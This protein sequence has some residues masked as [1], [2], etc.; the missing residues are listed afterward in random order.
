MALRNQGARRN[1]AIKNSF[2]KEIL[3]KLKLFHSY[4]KSEDESKHCM[5]LSFEEIMFC[6]VAREFAFSNCDLN[7]KV[8]SDHQESGLHKSEIHCENPALKE[9]CERLPKPPIPRPRSVFTTKLDDRNHDP[10]H[11]SLINAEIQPTEV[12]SDDGVS[13]IDCEEMIKTEPIQYSSENP[14]SCTGSIKNLVESVDVD[15]QPD[16]AK[17]EKTPPSNV[18]SI[19]FPPSFETFLSQ[20]LVFQIPNAEVTELG[21]K[22]ELFKTEEIPERVDSP[23]SIP[24]P[25]EK[26]IL[27]KASSLEVSHSNLSDAVDS[28][29]NSDDDFQVEVENTLELEEKITEDEKLDLMVLNKSE[30]V[31]ANDP[32][33]SFKEIPN[34][35]HQNKLEM[36]QMIT[37]QSEKRLPGKFC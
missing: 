27:A 37:I 35:D 29:L 13:I 19:I 36:L 12:H 14:T 5:Q 2:S 25:N 18:V 8:N 7:G 11:V 34:S 6:I 15:Q 9:I 31:E 28:K 20:S 16:P 26:S 1:D 21:N 17:E 33:Q 10:D 23:S 32:G 4:C 22:I 30:P 3:D 24:E